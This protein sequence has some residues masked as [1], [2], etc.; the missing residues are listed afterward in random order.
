MSYAE[1]VR[2][3]F[4]SLHYTTFYYKKK[5][6]D[7]PH[8]SMMIFVEEDYH[9]LCIFDFYYF[10]FRFHTHL[11]RTHSFSKSG[12]SDGDDDEGERKAQ[13]FHLGSFE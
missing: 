3:F 4:L 13:R 12:E 8:K 6:V 10:A 5:K 9:R 11:S 1:E 7:C 2:G